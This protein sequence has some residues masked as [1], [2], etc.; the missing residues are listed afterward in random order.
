MGSDEVL[1]RLFRHDSCNDLTV[2]KAALEE[3]QY[4]P[5][6]GEETRDELEEFA[7]VLDEAVEKLDRDTGRVKEL[8]YLAS[9]GTDYP[10]EVGRRVEKVSD[11]SSRLLDLEESS[12]NGIE[13]GKVL[14]PVEEEGKVNYRC[15]P[16]GK[17]EGDG[18]L[19]QVANTLVENSKRHGED[20][21]TTVWAEV[22]D[23][24]NCYSVDIWDNGEGLKDEYDGQDIFEESV[25]ENSG[26]G[27]YLSRMITENFDG[28]LRYSPENAARENGF[29]LKWILKKKEPEKGKVQYS[30]SEPV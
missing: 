30:T 26:L 22:A 4:G 5:E 11:M 2:I 6:L 9:H 24:D 12:Q 8:E 3:G 7:D 28:K 10:G 13:I 23:N 16:E 27:L 14:S 29:G 17:V 18:G 25:G 20:D 15:S 1:S 19:Y 21:D